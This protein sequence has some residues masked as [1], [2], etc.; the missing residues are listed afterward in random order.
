MG[1]KE[2]TL[3]KI[4][5]FRIGR[6]YDKDLGSNVEQGTVSQINL[7]RDEKKALGL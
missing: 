6:Q 4:H 3:C 1:P 7:E 5:H 2:L